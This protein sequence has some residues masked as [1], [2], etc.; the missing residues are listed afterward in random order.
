MSSAFPRVSYPDLHEL[1]RNFESQKFFLMTSSRKF[2]PTKITRYIM[3]HVVDHSFILL[4]LLSFSAAL[5]V[6]VFTQTGISLDPDFTMKATRGMIEEM[7]NNPG[8]FAGKRV[9]ILQT[10]I[11]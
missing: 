2:Q 8:R 5:I 10:G 1:P 6:D 7:K 11:Q 9:L 3:V 4:L